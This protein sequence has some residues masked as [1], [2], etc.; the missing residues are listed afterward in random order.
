MQGLEAQDALLEE[1]SS[2]GH[3]RG[4]NVAKAVGAASI[5]DF[6]AFFFGCSQETTGVNIISQ[7]Q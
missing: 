6:L 7:T 1:A 3:K 4:V 5:E 2:T